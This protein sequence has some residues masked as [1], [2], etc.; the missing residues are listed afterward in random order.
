MTLSS[1]IKDP[2][3]NYMSTQVI[4]N[5]MPPGGSTPYL[6]TLSDSIDITSYSITSSQDSA[7]NPIGLLSMNLLIKK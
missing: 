4:I 7:G 3:S 6:Q 5:P 2:E 1:L